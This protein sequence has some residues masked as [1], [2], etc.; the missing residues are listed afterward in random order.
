MVFVNKKIVNNNLHEWDIIPKIIV[1]E[2]DNIST[3][4]IESGEFKALNVL[5]RKHRP[6]FGG[7][8]IGHKKISSGT[9]MLC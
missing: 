7:L 6:I 1:T 2:K 3:D 4:V 9:R 8:S 5:Q